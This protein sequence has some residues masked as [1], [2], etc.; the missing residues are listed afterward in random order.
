MYR[1]RMNLRLNNSTFKDEIFIIGLPPN[2]GLKTKKSGRRMIFQY[3]ESI[4]FITLPEKNLVIFVKPFNRIGKLFY[5][6]TKNV[7]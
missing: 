1:H 5:L 7:K 3:R 6:M 4:F 2:Y